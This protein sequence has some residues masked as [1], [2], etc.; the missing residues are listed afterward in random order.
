MFKIETH[1]HTVHVS[2]CGHLD[3]KTLVRSYKEAG[4][5]AI[6]VTDHYNRNTVDYLS[7]DLSRPE[8]HLAQFLHGYDLMCEEGA[9]YGIRIYRGAEVRF[10]ECD[11]DYLLYNWPDELLADMGR[12]FKMSIVEFSRLVRKTD[13]F[14]M[15][16]HPY[17]KGCTPAI[18]CYLD[19]IEVFNGNPRHDSH[20]DRAREYADMFRL[21]GF[22]GSDCHQVTDIAV[23]G[24]GVEKLPENDAELASLFRAG[25]FEL[26]LPEQED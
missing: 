16:A 15:Q 19:G 9:R 25:K 2:K 12:T 17:R 14:L 23:S 21:T 5:D 11:N 3:A 10:D 24:I 13:A 22:A 18:A 4:Y 8:T 20:N 7:I 6:C 26:L 1:L